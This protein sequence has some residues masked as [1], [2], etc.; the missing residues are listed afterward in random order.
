M[1]SLASSRL[2]GDLDVTACD[3]EPIH[4]PGE[5]QPHGA[6]LV[7]DAASDEVTHAS[8]NLAAL[9]GCAPEAAFG[10]PL[11]ALLGQAAPQAGLPEEFVLAD[12]CLPAGPLTVS[13]RRYE[14]RIFAEFEPVAGPDEAAPNLPE[15]GAVLRDLRRARNSDELCDSA[16]RWLRRISGYDRTMVY[17]FDRD[18]HGEVVAESRAEG[19]DPYLGLRYPASDIPRQARRLYVRQPVRTI[20]DVAAVPV[21]L[22][23]GPG[24]G[25]EPVDM[26][27]CQ[28]RGVSPIHLHYL[29]NMGVGASFAVSLLRDDQLWGL[30]MGHHRT[31]RRAT[32]GLRGLG[33]VIGQLLSLTLHVFEE[34]ERFDDRL[35]RQVGLRNLAEA[36]ARSE[37]PVAEALAVAG[38]LLGIVRASGA[39]ITIGGHTVSAGQVP[40]PD[41]AV[42]VQ[43]QLLRMALGDVAASNEVSALLPEARA[44]VDLAAGAMVLPI[45]HAPGDA[46]VWY[47]P[48]VAQTVRWGGD[49]RKAVTTDPATGQLNPR[50]S[51]AAWREEVRDRS[52]PWNDVD[53][54]IARDLRAIVG[55]ALLRRAEAELRRLRDTDPLTGLPNRRSVQER[56]DAIAAGLMPQRV[57]LV[58][59]DLD[60]F[61]QVNDTL[62]HAAGD[63]LLVQV[64]GRLREVV[65]PEQLVARLGGDEFVVLCTGLEAGGTEALAERIRAKFAVPFDLAG[66]PYQAH[67]SI[68]VADSDRAGRGGSALLTA[69][70][71]AMYAAKRLGGNRAETFSVPVPADAMPRNTLEQD[72]R[73]AMLADCEQFFLDFQPIVALPQGTLRGLEALL[74]W[75]HPDRG[76]IGPAE[77]FPLVEKADLGGAVGVRVLDATLRQVRRWAARLPAGRTMPFV[78]V[79]MTARQL[80]H[81]DF[82][83]TAQRLLAS[84]GVAVG[85]LCIEVKE[86]AF[87]H[88]AAA[89][90]LAELRRRGIRV[91]VDDFGAGYSSLSQLRLLPADE[92]KL[93]SALLPRAGAVLAASHAGFLQAVLH[94]ARSAGLEVMAKGIETPSGLAVAVRSGIDAAQGFALARPIAAADVAA[95]LAAGR[96]RSWRAVILEATEAQAVAA[97]PQDVAG[98]PAALVPPDMLMAAGWRLAAGGGDLCLARF[99]PLGLEAIARERGRAEAEAVMMD[100]LRALR[101]AARGTDTLAQLGDAQIAVLMPGLDR[102][103]ALRIVRR[104]REA[105]R[106]ARGG[107]GMPDFAV[108]FAVTDGDWPERIL[109]LMLRSGQALDQAAAATGRTGEPIAEN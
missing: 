21:P 85:A 8:A 71:T 19:L 54:D 25:G 94:L 105:A 42:A 75:Q 37:A 92:V 69:A 67:A 60:R 102:V 90:T 55:E 96:A 30:L 100:A 15:M 32:S 1:N 73:A 83:V 104:L 2:S 9:L 86:D 11:K 64:A 18:G 66:R 65:P 40:P 84:Y 88:A 33:D 76:V 47:R 22:L 34:R 20:A 53:K 99:S 74:R 45:L 50:A 61:K 107:A 41:L 46:V 38:P 95:I 81:P 68:G 13:L 23:A 91:S 28:L 44:H 51:F 49:P 36:V 57:T 98:E 52:V 108:G 87:T 72:L 79:N 78:S 5:I 31:P 14:A 103:R 17:R 93:D 77:F 10:R 58:F 106:T 48:E 7:A 59:L 82:V 29:R 43:A 109:Q 4:I 80:M 6:L 3:L 63:A 26:T 89:A 70:D 35:S 101:R 97:G 62:G 27:C 39:T 12:A 24:I 56:L 16:V